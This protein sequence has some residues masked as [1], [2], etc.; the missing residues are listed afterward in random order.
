MDLLS[1][2][3]MNGHALGVFACIWVVA[4]ICLDM[5]D[6]TEDPAAPGEAASKS[7]IDD[8]LE[9]APTDSKGPAANTGGLLSDLI[10]GVSNSGVGQDLPLLLSSEKAAGLSIRGWKLSF[11]RFMPF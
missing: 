10:H 2:G 8:M 6:S 5:S 9:L 4:G 3:V 7:N 11:V 1:L